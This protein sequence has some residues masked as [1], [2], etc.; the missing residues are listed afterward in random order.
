MKKE[1]CGPHFLV[2]WRG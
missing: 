1:P 2:Q